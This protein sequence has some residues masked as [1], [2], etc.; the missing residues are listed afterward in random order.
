MRSI[1]VVLQN[2]KFRNHFEYVIRLYSKEFSTILSNDLII[3]YKVIRSKCLNQV[4]IVAKAA[5]PTGIISSGITRTEATIS[6]NAAI[7]ADF[8]VQD[9]K[10]VI[11]RKGTSSVIASKTEEGITGRTKTFSGL[12]VFTEYTVMISARCKRMLIYSD[13]GTID[14]RTEEGG[15]CYIQTLYGIIKL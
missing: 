12:D 1:T 13:A 6:W 8:Q 10:A 7:A 14:V 15:M 11:K 9:Y 4:L 5:A 2:M 3:C